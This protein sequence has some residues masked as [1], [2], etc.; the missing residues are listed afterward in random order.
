MSRRTRLSGWLQAVVGKLNILKSE[1][2]ELTGL[3]TADKSSHVAAINEV[4]AIADA[5]SGGGITID[6]AATN[7]AQTWSSTKINSEITAKITTAL[8]GED[9]SDIAGDIAALIQSDQGLVNALASQSFNSTQ[10]AQARTNIDAAGATDMG[11]PEYD[12]LTE[13]NGLISF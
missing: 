5:A 13:F 7:S 12:F 4:K 10:Q 1:L 8:E 2:G 6:D 3:S 9:L 11:D